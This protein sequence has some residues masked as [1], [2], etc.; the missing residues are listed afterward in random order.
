MQENKRW[1]RERD[2]WVVQGYVVWRADRHFVP[3]TDVIELEDKV[4][5]I[6]EI[7]G[8]R[9]TDFTVS[10]VNRQLV[11]SGMRERPTLPNAAYH[12]VEIGY[13]EFRVEVQL[14]QVVEGDG[15]TANYR[16]GFL[17]VELPRRSDGQQVIIHV[18]SEE[19]DER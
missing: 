9:A 6:V 12:Q 7:A 16:D 14:P 3:P 8:V 1:L 2:Q 10:L 18:N 13:G 17:Y 19:G 5:V 4:L 11:I 15:V